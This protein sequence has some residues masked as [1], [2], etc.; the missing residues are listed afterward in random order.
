MGG[1][2]RGIYLSEE[3]EDLPDSP[4]APIPSD[5]RPPV[6]FPYMEGSDYLQAHNKLLSS[7]EFP[8]SAAVC[9][10]IFYA[11]KISCRFSDCKS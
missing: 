2:L 7:A 5:A 4:P 10:S 3:E 11:I 8:N 6:A 9:I 1:R